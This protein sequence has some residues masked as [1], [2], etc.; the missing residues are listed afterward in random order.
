MMRK[1]R[2][3]QDTN[4]CRVCI[5]ESLSRILQKVS[6]TLYQ[7]SK[8][9]PSQVDCFESNKTIAGYFSF[10]YLFLSQLH[11]LIIHVYVCRGWKAGLSS[12]GWTDVLLG[13]F[14]IYLI[15]NRNID[16]TRCNLLK[17]FFWLE[18]R[19][20]KAFSEFQTNCRKTVGVY[21]RGSLLVSKV[22]QVTNF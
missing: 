17:C 21:I 13:V 20:K 3:T 16:R 1:K 10:F 9:K 14:F 11:L 8:G 2:K 4:P 5:Y 18:I 12:S 15:E 6:E 22:L 19:Q 7:F